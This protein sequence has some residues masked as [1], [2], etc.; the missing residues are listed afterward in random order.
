MPILPS[1]RRIEFSADRFHALLRLVDPVQA[2]RIAANIQDAHDL[3]F[4]LDAV[5]FS[6]QDGT[7]YFA[8]Y[9][10]ADWRSYAADW[11]TADRE[12][13]E[14]WLMS[15]EARAGRD[16]AMRYV[17]SLVF[18]LPNVP[19]PYELAHDM[20]VVGAHSGSLLRQ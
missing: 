14:A 4:V 10:A 20:H 11:N 6:V 19:Y 15:D 7:P 2:R 5:H 3:L 12:A 13:L 1:G 18:G 9:V 16:E 17:K 8:G